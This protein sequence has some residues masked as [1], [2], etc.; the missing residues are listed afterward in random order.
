M[1]QHDPEVVTQVERDTW[2]RLAASYIR[3]AEFSSHAVS[4][5]IKSARLT[6]GSRALEVGC[7][8]G[9]ALGP[10]LPALNDEV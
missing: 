9:S 6:S 1:K 3:A 7:G 5:L 2:N 8:P 10:A 4:L